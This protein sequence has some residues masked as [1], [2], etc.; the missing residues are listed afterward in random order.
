MRTLP[1]SVSYAGAI[2]SSVALSP[3]LHYIRVKDKDRSLQRH[4]IRDDW[5]QRHRV[6]DHHLHAALDPPIV[7][8]SGVQGRKESYL[9]ASHV[10]FHNCTTGDFR[11][12]KIISEGMQLSGR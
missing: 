9:D 7:T 11:A 2:H 10:S 1:L 5:R 3:L 8:P 6:Y 12:A 4:H